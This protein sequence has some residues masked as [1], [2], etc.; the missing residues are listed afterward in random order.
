MNSVNVHKTGDQLLAMIQ[1]KYPGYHPIVHAADIAHDNEASLSIH[2]DAIKTM[3]KYTVPDVKSID[4]SA[5]LS[6]GL[7]KLELMAFGLDDL[8]DSIIDGE[9]IEADALP[10]PC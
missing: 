4:I 7:D 10:A 6:G 9:I 2:M 5:R 8:E 1:D 3:L